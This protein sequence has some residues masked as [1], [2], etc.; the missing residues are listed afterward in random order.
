MSKA[1]R[2]SLPGGLYPINIYPNK[3]LIH[4]T[5]LMRTKPHNPL[6]KVNIVTCNNPQTALSP[7]EQKLLTTSLISPFP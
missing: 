2:L 1:Q 4:L 6:P 5:Y 3:S 7:K